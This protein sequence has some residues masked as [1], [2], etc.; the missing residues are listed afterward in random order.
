M[1]ETKPIIQKINEVNYLINNNR[2]FL[3]SKDIN[4]FPCSRRG[5]I[6]T[7]T[8]K[9]SS[10]ICYDPE[11]RLNTERTNRIGTAINGFTDSFII[12]DDFTSGNTLEFVLKGYRVE[13]KSFVPS[14]IAEALGTNTDTIYA[15][16]SLHDKISL[17]VPDY[18]TEILY[19]QSLELNDKNYLDVSYTYDE[20]DINGTILNGYADDFFVGISFTSNEDARDTGV[21]PYFLSLFSKTANSDWE[22]VQTSLLPKVEHDTTPNSI[23][24]RGDFTVNHGEQTSFKVTKDETRLGPTQIST[25]TVTGATDLNAVK[26]DSLIVGEVAEGEI[27]P[28]SGTIIAKHLVEAPV[29][30]A[31]T[32]IDTPQLGTAVLTSD[33]PNNPEIVVDP[34]KALKVNTIDS[35]SAKGLTIKQ[36]ANLGNTLS[37]TGKTTLKNGLEVASGETTLAGKTTVSNNL[38]VTGTIET[39]KLTANT[40]TIQQTLNVKKAK[41]AENPAEANIDKA[42]IENATI[43]TASMTTAGMVT[44]NIAQANATNATITT[45]KIITANIDAANI[46]KADI[47]GA[48]VTS[49]LNIHNDEGDAQLNADKAIITELEVTGDTQLQAVTINGVTKANDIDATKIT[50]NEIWLDTVDNESIGQVPAL[51]LAH[52]TETDTYQL[53]FKFGTPITITEE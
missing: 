38:S 49:T 15:H 7:I 51:E 21:T 3:P 39:P 31:T 25:L 8:E 28:V 1:A 30:V 41:G 16:L 53:R 45:A 37:V 32:A 22:L 10:M 42:I 27:F 18:Y 17:N 13:I 50:A 33:D 12:N 52:L 26:A 4:I 9:G 29:I 35:D 40:A 5:S 6:G 11:A 48:A 2:V 23:K 24:L 44:A 47:S 20:K 19:R 36:A 34:D 14:A 43:T 46:T